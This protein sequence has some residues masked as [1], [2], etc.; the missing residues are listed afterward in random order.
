MSE[1]A[2]AGRPAILVPLPTAMD[3]HQYYNANV[4]EKAGCGWV[5]AQDGFTPEAVSA[6]LEAF[7]T[8]PETLNRAAENART[9]GAQD[10][11]RALAELVLAEGINS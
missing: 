5:M 7:L 4:F 8:A 10:A 9:F 3:N 6:R 11:A 2:V 1:L